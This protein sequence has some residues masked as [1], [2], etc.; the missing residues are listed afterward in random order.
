MRLN[1][2]RSTTLATF[3]TLA[4]LITYASTSAGDDLALAALQGGNAKRRGRRRR[5]RL[6]QSPAFAPALGASRGP[7]ALFEEAYPKT[8]EGEL[9]A[10]A[11][12][13]ACRVRAEYFSHDLGSFGRWH[14]RTRSADVRRRGYLWS[15]V[16]WMPGSRSNAL[17]GVRRRRFANLALTV[18]LLHNRPCCRCFSFSYVLL[19]ARLLTIHHDKMANELY[20]DV[21]QRTYGLQVVGL[22]SFNVF[23]R[24]QDPKGA[25]AAVIPSLDRATVVGAGLRAVRRRRDES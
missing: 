6:Q 24:R 14:L 7:L 22:R 2:T 15:G 11:A 23:G 8:K 3:N 9:S 20:A 18:P 5:T 1:L 16:N 19:V 12:H 13:R 17:K 25:Y 21:F 10:S 4:S